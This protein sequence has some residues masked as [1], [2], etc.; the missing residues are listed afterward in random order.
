MPLQL[1]QSLMRSTCQVMLQLCD[2]RMMYSL[3]SSGRGPGLKCKWRH[4]DPHRQAMDSIIAWI[5]SSTLSVVWDDGSIGIFLLKGLAVIVFRLSGLGLV[6][7]PGHIAWSILTTY[8]GG[9]CCLFDVPICFQGDRMGKII[10]DLI[11]LLTSKKHS[12]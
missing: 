9:D 6:G 11:T 10:C 5:F 4:R 3:T 2:F 8:M 12:K 1:Y 7:S